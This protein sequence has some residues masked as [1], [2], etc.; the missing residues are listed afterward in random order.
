M[1]KYRWSTY[2][3][4]AVCGVVGVAATTFHGPRDEPVVTAVATDYHLALPETLTAGPTEFRLENRGRELHHV[5][6]VRL[7][8]GKTAN[9]FA[10][11]LKAGGPP[12]TW[13]IPM[14]GPNGVDPG[15]TSLTT[16]VPLTAGRYAALCIIPGPDGVPHVMKG[17]IAELRVVPG[18]RKTAMPTA[19]DAT[20]RLL[21]Y[22]FDFSHPITASTRSILVRND[23]K[24]PHELEIARLEPGKTPA[25][26]AAWAEKMV[27]R[28]PAHFLGGVSP[29]APGQANELSLS[30]PPGRYVLLCFVPDVKDA[31]PHTAHGMVRD[32]IVR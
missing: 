13:A 6:I 32:F 3:A 21:D 16:T 20:V 15:A 10:Q 1:M 12:P 28:P 26:L 5:F 25:D 27:G 22:A 8:P 11:A 9:D 17:M 24:Q 30:L 31:K 2:T 14:G 29:I 7:G 23:G 19:T 18:A 4:V